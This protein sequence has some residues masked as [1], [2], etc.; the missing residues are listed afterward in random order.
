MLR[1]YKRI[2][3]CGISAVRLFIYLII[4]R[5]ALPE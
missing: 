2:E 5:S 4:K 1:P 3:A